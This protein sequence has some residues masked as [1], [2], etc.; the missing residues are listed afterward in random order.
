MGENKHEQAFVKLKQT[1]EEPPAL[2]LPS[3]SEPFTSFAH[4]KDN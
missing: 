2:G 1:L 4:E 3:Y